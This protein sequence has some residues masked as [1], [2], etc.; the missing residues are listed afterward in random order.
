MKGNIIRAFLATGAL[1]AVCAASGCVADRPS[2]NGVFNENQYIRKDFLIQPGSGGVDP[3]WFVK[4][5]ILSTSVPNPLASADVLLETGLHGTYGNYV[6][7]GVTSDR[8]LMQDMV[9]PTP[10]QT[11]TGSIAAQGTRDASTVDSWSVTNVDLKYRVNLDGE[12]TNFYEENQEL[13]WQQRQWVKLSL[14]K[15]DQSD[16]VTFGPFTNDFLAKCT[17]AADIA[18]TLHPGSF[19]VD[20]ANNYWQFAVDITI[21]LSFGQ[22]QSQTASSDGTNTTSV[23]NYCATQFA[24]AGWMFNQLGRTNVTMTLMYSFMR[25]SENPATTYDGGQTKQATYVP[26]VIPEKD[27]IQRKYGIIN[28]R[29][30]AIDPTT[31]LW[32]SRQLVTRHDPKAAVVTRYFAPGFPNYLK[33]VYGNPD[34]PGCIDACTFSGG[35]NGLIDQTNALFKV[36]GATTKLVIKDFDA[37]L[38]PGQPPRQYGDARYSFLVW[39]SDL[40]FAN[41][42]G[43]LGITYGSNFDIRT[44]QILSTDIDYFDYPWQDYVL[45]RLDYYEQSIGAFNFS[46]AGQ[47]G[48]PGSCQDGDVIPLVPATVAANHNGSSTLFQKMQQYLGK[49][50]STWGNLGPS[51]FIPQH[52]ADF[53]NGLFAVLPYQIFGDPGANPYVIAEGGTANY[54]SSTS[55]F[56]AGQG[57]ADFQS[58]MS[59]IDHGKAPFDVNADSQPGGGAQATAF[60]AHLQS[61]TLAHRDYLYQ[62]DYAHPSV[63]ADDISMYSFPVAFQKNGRHCIKGQ[64][65]TRDQYVTN[66]VQSF[67][68]SFL[69]HEFGHS[70]GLE[71][72]FMGS[73]D[74]NNYPHYKDGAGRDHI[75]MY[76]S[77]IMEYPSAID[78]QF[79][80]GTANAALGGAAGKFGWAPYDQAAIA[81]IYANNAASLTASDSGN[82]TGVVGASVSGQSGV[83][84]NQSGKTVT[85]ANARW[86]DPLGFCPASGVNPGTGFACTPGAETQFLYCTNVNMKYTPFCREFDF[87]TTPAE[88]IASEIDRY[89]WQYLWS[90]FPQ[91]HQYFSFQNYA[92][93]PAAF[94]TD[95]RR[96]LASWAYDWSQGE[97]SD[98]FRRLGVNPPAGVPALSYYD[99]LANAFNQDISVANQLYAAASEGVI[100]QSAGQ[101][102]FVTIFDPYFG[103]TTQQGIAVDKILSQQAFTALWAVDDY[104]QNQSAGAY[105]SPFSFQADPQYQAVSEAMTLAVVGGSYDLFAY[106]K[107]LGVQQFA[108]ATHSPYFQGYGTGGRPEIKDWIGGYVFTRESDFLDFF[109]LLAVN[110]NTVD[111]T[112]ARICP[113][114]VTATCGY[115]PRIPGTTNDPQQA[116]HSDPFNQFQGPDYR[117]W[118]W[119]YMQD[120]NQWIVA[121]RDRNVATYIT[122][123][124]YTSD[125]IYGEDDGNTG[126]PYAIEL[127]L[128]YFLNYYHTNGN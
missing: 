38:A 23:D 94:F 125:V 64:W 1:A 103:D 102:P 126:G 37:D 32:G 2:R 67:R 66:L 41:A 47:N 44:G 97:L 34:T 21:P 39:H 109:R 84:L 49:P 10:D 124:T 105:L 112:G 113:T 7:F 13:D 96:F 14:D 100:L 107:P 27:N 75:G 22:V 58:L 15:N 108:M 70:L 45:A 121:D 73:V 87:G 33:T 78:D 110:N 119:V 63:K 115:D 54:G 24:Y 93:V 20:E 83:A 101:R 104:D 60:L 65:E 116:F 91:Y 5:T 118:I 114:D 50:V 31:G 19:Y 43:L 72:N 35:G 59:S 88:I 12:K 86:K 30:P 8:L 4:T 48:V 92:N 57:E 71:H 53:Y 3:G 120:S 16:F 74:R 17:A 80:S 29:L 122:A 77:S 52:D 62:R 68:G 128:K 117:R 26:L 55:L 90:N 51:D 9:Q 18:S 69:W 95:G 25:A 127:P 81:F 111:A 99:D 36:A 123:Y 79:W 56:A 106:A 42:T 46:P 28:T 6:N 89:E 11:L 61:A 82:P 98:N 85:A 76:S 40:G